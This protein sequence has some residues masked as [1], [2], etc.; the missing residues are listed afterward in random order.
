[1]SNYRSSSLR[2]KP[3]GGRSKSARRRAEARREAE[4]LTVTV[5]TIVVTLIA[6]YDL[7]L[8]ASHI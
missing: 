7:M 1:M 8:F 3:V 2:A 6:L 5:L 4:A